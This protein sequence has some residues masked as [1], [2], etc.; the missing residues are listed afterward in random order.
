MGLR[1]WWVALC[2]SI[3]LAALLLHEPIARLG[4]HTLGPWDNLV[5]QSAQSRGEQHERTASP[6]LT[7]PAQQFVR[8]AL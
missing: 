1:E 2:G 3:L 4:A 7:D 5:Q 6:A 8:W